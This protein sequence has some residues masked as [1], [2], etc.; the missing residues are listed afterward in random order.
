MKVD[1]DK[2]ARDYDVYRRGGGPYLRRLTAL[3]NEVNAR[4]VLEI[5]CGTGNNT[6]A[7]SADYAGF[8]IGLDLSQGMLTQA[9]Q[10]AINA[11]W[12]QGSAMRLP[13]ADRRIDFIF[14]VYML[15]YVPKLKDFFAECHRV[16]R[17]GASAFVTA[18]HEYIA[19]HPMNAYFP[20]FASIDQTRF[21]A[22]ATIEETMRQA[23]FSHVTHDVFVDMPR[24]LGMEYVRKVEGRFISTFN[25][26]PATEYA[27]GLARLRA[28]VETKGQL[29]EPL[30]WE[31][32][33]VWATV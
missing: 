10:K 6:A 27:Q 32:V 29:D 12:L 1:Y 28:D 26:L 16:L 22:V 18:S 23:G 3:A 8:L 2:I 21:P 33:V 30:A 19:R 15:H 20:S 9:R 4:T 5:G 17:Q 31:S 24:S 11:H 14:G 7:F 25:L 13:F